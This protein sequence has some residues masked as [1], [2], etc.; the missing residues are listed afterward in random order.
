MYNFIEKRINNLM[1]DKELIKLFLDFKRGEYYWDKNMRKTI[2]R[3][4][5]K[6]D[7]INFQLKILNRIKCYF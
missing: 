1:G 5:S 3:A 7:R 4:Y 2:K 6:I